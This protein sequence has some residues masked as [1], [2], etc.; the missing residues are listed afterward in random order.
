MHRRACKRDKNILNISGELCGNLCESERVAG[1]LNLMLYV[2]SLNNMV[3]TLKD[4]EI[5]RNKA[6]RAKKALGGNGSCNRKCMYCYRLSRFVLY[7][8]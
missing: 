7:T 6:R 8:F 3:K 5:K 2:A 1:D 4:A